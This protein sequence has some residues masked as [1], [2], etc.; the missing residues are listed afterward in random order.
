MNDQT[1]WSSTSKIK[2]LKHFHKSS[3]QMLECANIIDNRIGECYH[4]SMKPEPEPFRANLEKGLA[5]CSLLH[6]LQQQTVWN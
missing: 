6:L 4:T 2:A 5:I 1:I 3:T